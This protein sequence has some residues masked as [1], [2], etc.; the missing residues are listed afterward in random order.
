[1]EISSS[2][3]QLWIILIPGVIAI[4]LMSYETDVRSL[5]KYEW[6]FGALMS[7][8]LIFLIYSI[9]AWVIS[10]NKPIKLALIQSSYVVENIT[11]LNISIIF[12]IIVIYS[13]CL[14]V[15]YEKDLLLRL[16]NKI[17]ISNKLSGNVWENTLKKYK[18][19]WVRIY[20]EK[21]FYALGWMKYFSTGDEKPAVFL[22]DPRYFKVSEDMKNVEEI[23]VKD[24]SERDISDG[25][26]VFKDIKR[27]EIADLGDEAEDDAASP[28]EG[29]GNG[30]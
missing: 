4:Q 18:N 12:I 11:P 5:G 17:G 15:I 7:S 26:L 13:I 8:W 6:F 22:V 1:M 20:L 19:N 30:G 29:G 21:D 25:I 2:L 27:I 16:T 10:I 14:V 9:V 3:L 23:V 28:N 24:E